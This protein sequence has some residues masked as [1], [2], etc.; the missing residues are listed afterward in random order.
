[1]ADVSAGRSRERR[2]IRTLQ[3]PVRL[4]GQRTAH[5][6]R[7]PP[8][9]AAGAPKTRSVLRSSRRHGF[10]AITSWNCATSSRCSTNAISCCGQFILTMP[11][12]TASAGFLLRPHQVR[13]PGHTSIPPWPSRRAYVYERNREK[14]GRTFFPTLM[15]HAPLPR[16]RRARRRAAPRKYRPEQI[17]YRPAP[18]APQSPRSAGAVGPAA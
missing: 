4:L 11:V 8:P 1:V 17:T 15:P 2:R 7:P 13:E 3:P 10:F 6:R 12:R 14:P 16:P 9:S 5:C 18:A